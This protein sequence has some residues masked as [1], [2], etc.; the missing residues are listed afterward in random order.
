MLVV[1]FDLH[2]GIHVTILPLCENMTLSTK[3][4]VHNVSQRRAREGLSQSHRRHA[5]KFEVQLCGFRVMRADRQT[6]KQTDIGYFSQY[7]AP[8]TETIDVI[9]VLCVY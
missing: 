3:P 2:L 7:L 5:Q 1:M 6:E 9:T 4:E 8:L